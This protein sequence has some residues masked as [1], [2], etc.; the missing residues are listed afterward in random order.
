MAWN[1]TDHPIVK[2]AK[3]SVD[4][5]GNIGDIELATLKVHL[6]LEDGL[7]Y[8]LAARLGLPK[9]ETALSSTRIDFSLLLELALSGSVNPHLLGAL[10]ALNA[11]RNALSHEVESPN[12]QDRLAA[13]CGEIGYMTGEKLTWPKERGE[14]IVALRN[15]F[16]EA[17]AAIFDLAVNEEQKHERKSGA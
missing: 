8:L 13:F 14:Q 2:W 1:E 10:R 4:H 7:R 15:A 17:G 5:L 12:V 16:D 3:M 9:S 11:A 6:V